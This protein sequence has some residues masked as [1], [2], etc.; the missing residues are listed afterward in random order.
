MLKTNSRISLAVQWLGLST[1]KAGVMDSISDQG[2]K[3][4]HAT[5]CGIKKKKTN[6]TYFH[7]QNVEL[8]LPGSEEGVKWEVVV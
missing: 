3:I 2:T 7:L 4:L 5:W 1:S 8:W 6:T